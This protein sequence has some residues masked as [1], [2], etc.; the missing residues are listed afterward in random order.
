MSIAG[1][2]HIIIDY[3]TFHLCFDPTS[4]NLLFYL[5]LHF[6]NPKFT[7]Q[8]QQHNNTIAYI[9]FPNKLFQIK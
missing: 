9:T 7:E 1:E 3:S 4:C 2:Y 8:Q 5:I 6:T